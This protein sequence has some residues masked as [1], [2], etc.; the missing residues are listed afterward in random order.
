[1]TRLNFTAVP[2]TALLA[3]AL[4]ATT[5]LGACAPLI[6]GGAMVGTALSVT[7]RR[8][9]GTQLED[10]GIELKAIARLRDALGDR[11]HI[12]ITSYNRTAL[13]TGE[14]PT[15][16]DRSAAEQAITR[17]ENV[18]ATVNEL[19]VMGNSSLT[20]RSSDAI[21]TSKVKA[22][23]IDAKDLQANAI[24][25]VAERGTVYLLGRVTEREA[26]RATELARGVSGVGKVVKVFEVISEAEL[27]DLQPKK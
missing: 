7:D 5:L 1:M 4:A 26:N 24:K 2:R 23:Y 21:I 14:V 17:I 9:S 13:L 27:A 11:G 25:V 15:E 6:V 20:A 16:A 3:A 22:S 10:E 12:S 19:A 18:R 8:T